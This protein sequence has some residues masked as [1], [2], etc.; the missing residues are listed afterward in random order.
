MFGRKGS[1]DMGFS[2]RRSQ[3]FTRASCREDTV[4]PWPAACARVVSVQ[5]GRKPGPPS[6]RLR[7]SVRKLWSAPFKVGADCFLEWRSLN[8]HHSFLLVS[9]HVSVKCEVAVCRWSQAR[10]Q[11]PWFTGRCTFL[12]S[13]I[14]AL[15]SNQ[16]MRSES[17]LGGQ[18]ASFLLTE[19][20]LDQGAQGFWGI[21]GVWPNWTWVLNC[22]FSEEAKKHGEVDIRPP[23]FILLPSCQV[24][25]WEIN[26][27]VGVRYVLLDIFCSFLSKVKWVAKSVI[28]KEED[29]FDVGKTSLSGFPHLCCCIHYSSTSPG[30]SNETH[31]D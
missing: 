7:C 3:D 2:F 23:S 29:E 21:Y 1:S 13:L 26:G 16:R 27:N 22:D 18:S 25:R 4:V 30:N 24:N 31:I 11:N 28:Q 15:G 20:T 8:T 14:W 6:K 5:T 9:W 17:V 12:H 10:R 19:S